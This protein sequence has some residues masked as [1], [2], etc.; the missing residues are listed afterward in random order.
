MKDLNQIE[1]IVGAILEYLET[2]QALDLLPQIAKKLTEKS[3]A[4][5]DPNLALVSSAVK[6]SANQQA[7]VR[8]TLARHFQRPIRVK[9]K[10]D[11]SIIGGFKI[12]VAG[13]MIDATVNN[14]LESLKEKVIYG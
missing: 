4:K 6:L 13:K 7:L 8:Q 14:R 2:N 1:T 12:S 3:W 10:I 11:P 5:I 9:T